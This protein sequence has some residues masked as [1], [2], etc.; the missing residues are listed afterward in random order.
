MAMDQNVVSWVAEIGL[1]LSRHAT[2]QRRSWSRWPFVM[3]GCAENVCPL[4]VAEVTRAEAFGSVAMDKANAAN[5]RRMDAHDV[6]SH[7]IAA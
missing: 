4:T 5:S 6:A 1:P 2:T 7:L 3:V